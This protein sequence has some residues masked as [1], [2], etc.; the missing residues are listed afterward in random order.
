MALDLAT[1]WPLVYAK[2]EQEFQALIETSVRET[3]YVKA[4]Q[5]GF[6]L[7][8]SGWERFE[9]LEA[10]RPKS[11]TAFVAMWFDPRME[12][13]YDDGS[14]RATRTRYDPIG[15]TANLH[16]QIDDSIIASIRKSVLLVADFTDMR[17]GVFFE[18]GFGLGLGIPVVWTC[19]QDDL[20]KASEHFDTRQYNHLAWTD[21]ADLKVKLRTRIEA[22][23]ISRPR[24]RA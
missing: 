17:R 10:E 21:P 8:R 22:A 24:P 4:N 1:D 6:G 23:V 16:R 19:R 20:A 9:Q 13:A 14:A 3:G 12:P 2:D 11:T 15:W 5:A 18:A 7:T